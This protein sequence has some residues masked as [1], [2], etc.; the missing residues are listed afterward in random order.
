MTKKNIQNKESAL[1]ILDAL[2]NEYPYAGCHLDYDY[3]IPFQLLIST[4]FA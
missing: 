4:L 1:K 2:S 3:E